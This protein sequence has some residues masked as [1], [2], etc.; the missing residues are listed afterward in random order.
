MR[1]NVAGQKTGAQMVSAVDGSPFT[2]AVTVYVTIDAAT[3]AIGSVGSGVCTHEGNGYHTYSPSQAETNGT[4]I[5]FTFVGTGAVP[6]TVQ[7]VV[8]DEVYSVEYATNDTA[9]TF[10]KIFNNFRKGNPAINGEVVAGTLTA[11]QFSS[12]VT[13]Y[14][15]D[16]LNGAT[17][18][19]LSGTYTDWVS[20]VADYDPT[21]GLI[22]LERPLPAAPAA[23]VEFVIQ[24]ASYVHSIASITSGVWSALLSGMNVAGSV[25]ALMA[26]LWSMVESVAGVFRWKATSLTQAPTG[27]AGGDGLYARTLIASSPSGNV[28]GVTFTVVGLPIRV[29][30]GTSGTAIV[31]LD[32]ETYTIRTAVPPGYEQVSDTTLVVSASGS[33]TISLTPVP[34]PSPPS[35][36]S[37]LLS[38]YVRN[39]STAPADGI[40]VTARLPKGWSVAGGAMNINEVVTDV[41]DS[42]G[43]AQLYLIREQVYELSFSRPNGTIA[44]IPIETPD[45]ATATLTQ[46]YTG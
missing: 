7:A 21:N 30:T 17:L 41:T 20:P 32:A 16:T 28:Q 1:K 29:T 24:P 6:A 35:A 31:N 26:A 18:L 40:T 42:T 13:S 38:V 8:T 45:A 2:G 46:S 9:G 14:A 27:G 36:N 37:C 23:G 22:T 34:I 33:T 10:G 12:N 43:L 19:I 25:G 15:A 3:Q 4:L 44:K 11:S 5:A 39:Q